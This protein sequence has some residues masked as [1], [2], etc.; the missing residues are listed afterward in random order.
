MIVSQ[1][2]SEIDD[3]ILSQCGTFIALR[4]SNGADRAKVQAT[5]PDNLSA[6]TEAL[7]ILRTGEAIITGEAAPLPIRCRLGLPP[8]G[9][10][11]DSGDPSVVAA[12]GKKREAEDYTTIVAAWRA[13]NPH[14]KKD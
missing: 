13:Q 5:L 1:R 9:H 4:L 11:R 6:V 12:W 2:P 14:I 10:R 8:V 3:T 7:S